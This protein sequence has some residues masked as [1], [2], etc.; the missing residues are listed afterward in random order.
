MSFLRRAALAAIC[1]A[2]IA[3]HPR[4][5]SHIQHLHPLLQASRNP[6]GSGFDPT[7]IGLRADFKLTDFS[8]LKG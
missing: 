2:C 7:S 1:G 5:L 6:H 4:H 8:K 3:T